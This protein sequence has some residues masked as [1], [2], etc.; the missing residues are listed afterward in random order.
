M[1]SLGATTV[2]M[3]LLLELAQ[4]V[5]NRNTE[6]IRE[7]LH[8]YLI[9]LAL[10]KAPEGASRTEIPKIIEE[11]FDFSDFPSSIIDSALDRLSKNLKIRGTPPKYSIS[12][13]RKEQL[14]DMF[15]NQGMLR[16]YFIARILTTIEN[17]YGQISNVASD[18]VIDCVFKFLA[19]AFNNLS[20]DLA[21]LISKNPEKI[22]DVTELLKTGEILVKSFETIEDRVLMRD[23]IEVVK[24]NL[25]EYDAKTALFLYSLAQSYVLLKILNIDPQCQTLQKQAILSDMVVYLDTNVVIHLLCE[26]ANPRVH[27]T[28]VRLVNMMNALGM[29]CLISIRTFKEIE[30]HLDQADK[31]Y[32]NI[33]GIPQH[34]IEK[35]LRYIQ[36]EILKEY[37]TALRENPGFKWATFLGRLRKF[38]SIL[39]GRYSI[40]I[41]KKAHPEV[42]ADPR[43]EELLKL[44]EE[45]NPDKS[46]ALLEH[47]CFHLLLMDH[48][49]SEMKNEAIL[50]K[51]WFLTRDR[52]LSVVEKMRI[53]TEKKRP[54]SAHIDVWLQMIS[55]LLSPKIAT[56]QASEIFARCFSS[57]LMPSF[58]RISP[59]LLAKLIGPCLDHADLNVHE[60][61]EIVGDTYLREHFVGM[62]EEKVGAYLTNKLIEIREAEHRKKTQHSEEEKKILR[63]EITKLEEERDE[64]E[65]DKGE[66]VE[67]L[68]SRK[69]IARYLAGAATFF[70]VWILT[71]SLV[72]L[73]TIGD[74]RIA[75]LLSI[76]VS[77]IFGYLLGFKRYEWIL[78]KFLDIVG[79]LKRS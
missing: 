43:F 56:E 9:E 15:Q 62:G 64:L 54:T 41:D 17:D 58:P 6:N 70:L 19:S 60:V 76:L 36:D 1:S 52:T 59:D 2:E 22:K 69:F 16:D 37:W 14:S 30:K 20:I 47:D 51:R 12:V 77:L 66:L 26:K 79:S 73:P 42:Y 5:L 63:Q 75:C 57:D 27:S 38:S 45:S 18:Q 78:Q 46:S 23:S 3:R 48:L 11:E 8:N 50:P 10:F 7:E 61:V 68:I 53:M 67:E 32:Q 39:K 65:K 29:K 44:V 35:L 21:R 28:C 74:P 31:E 40:G 71:Y 55:P 33:G 25:V 49:R 13:R 34:R 72:L 4:F 24:K